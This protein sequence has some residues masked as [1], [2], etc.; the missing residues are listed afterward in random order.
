MT[1]I[2]SIAGGLLILF[3]A[4]FVLANWNALAI[5]VFQ[6]RSATFAPLLGGFMLLTG[7]LIH[8]HT[9][10]HYSDLWWLGLVIDFTVPLA[11]VV[12]IWAALREA[13]KR[14]SSARSS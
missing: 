10:T 6:K 2:A 3:G 9:R 13:A 5:R 8:P 11:I 7:W 14:K 1:I 4:M 12:L